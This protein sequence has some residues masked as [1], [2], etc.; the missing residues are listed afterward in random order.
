MWCEVPFLLNKI[1]VKYLEKKRNTYHK[2][3]K[4]N[5]I[6]KFPEEISSLKHLET[7]DVDYLFELSDSLIIARL[8]KLLP[9]TAINPSREDFYYFLDDYLRSI[10]YQFKIRL[11]V[12]VEETYHYRN[13]QIRKKLNSKEYKEF[14]SNGKIKESVKVDKYGRFYG[15]YI[16]YNSDGSVIETIFLDPEKDNFKYYADDIFHE[17]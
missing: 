3:Y 7:L 15:E 8:T 4:P 5:S 10:K 1:Q 16:K 12:I 14:Y 17:Q 9:N 2:L 6:R 11:G 13:G